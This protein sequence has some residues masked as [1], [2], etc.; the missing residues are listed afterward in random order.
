MGR[1]PPED[2]ALPMI[3]AL[4]EDFFTAGRLLL[5]AC[6]ACSAVQHP[7]EHVCRSCQGADFESRESVGTGTV[8]SF[9]VAHYPA[10]PSLSDSVPYAAV[11]VELDDYKHVRLTGNVLDVEPSEVAI[12]MRVRVVWQEV[13]DASGQMLKIPQ[14]QRAEA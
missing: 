4:N 7:P 1:I 13:Q 3:D 12:G 8:Y 6:R 2:W 9:T 5:Q 14:W 11:L 10:H